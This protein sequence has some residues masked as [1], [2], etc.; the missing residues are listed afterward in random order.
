MN[1]QFQDTA[2][3]IEECLQQLRTQLAQEYPDIPSVARRRFVMA[4][5]LATKVLRREKCTTIRFDKN[6]VEYPAGSILPLYALEEGQHHG[7]ARC[8]ADLALHGVR[9]EQVDDLTEDDALADGFNSKEELIDTLESFYG[10]L[11]PADVVCIYNFS[12]IQMGPHRNAHIRHATAE[13]LS[14]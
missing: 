3:G 12:L 2:A 13:M 9:Y 7:E 14:V 10:Q 8:M 5:H 1:F 4:A 6:A 11:A